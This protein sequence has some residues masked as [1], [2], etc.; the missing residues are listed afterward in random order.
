M[1]INYLHAIVLLISI[2]VRLLYLG[3]LVI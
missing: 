1:Y 3:A 2:L